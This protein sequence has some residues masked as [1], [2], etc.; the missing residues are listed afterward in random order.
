MWFGASLLYRSSEPLDE[1]G[2]HLYEERIILLEAIDEG[3]AWKKANERG[4]LLEEEYTN[5]EGRRVTWAFE[6]AIEVKEIIE[7]QLGD[8]VEVFNRFLSE[9]EARNL[10]SSISKT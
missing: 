4:P 5:A 1:R 9:D 2:T 10:T 3:E 8:G 7:D 6:R